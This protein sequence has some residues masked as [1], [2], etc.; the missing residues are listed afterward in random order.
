MRVLYLSAD[1]GVPVLGHKGASVHVR[2]L[3]EA[4]AAAGAEVA[5]ASPRIAFEGEQLEAAA[6]L[7]QIEPVLP[8][9]YA[10]EALLRG[11]VDRQAEQIADLASGLAVDAVYERFSLFSDGGVRAAGLLGVPHLLEVN[12]PLREEAL[13]FRTLPHSRLAEAIERAV[14]D[15]TDRVFVVS[16]TLAELLVAAG[17]AP[18]KIECVRNGVD[19]QAFGALNPVRGGEFTVGF[20]GSLK[21][22]HGV[23]VLLEGFGLALAHEPRLRLEVVG[24]GPLATRVVAS[25]L[26]AERLVYRG[27]LTH[28]EAIRA[29]AGWDVGAAPF[30]R[31]EDFYFSPLKVG[32]YMAAGSCPVASDLPVLRGLLA[33]GERGI[34]V[35]PGSAEAFA[36]ALVELA[37][38]RTRASVLGMRARTYALANL[39]WS[40]NAS[41]V[42]E[43]LATPVGAAP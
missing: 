41:R 17:V 8:K 34:L 9:T 14:L 32:E 26:P 30:P 40:E 39:S 35:E 15:L 11:A 36:A 27:Q 20:A 10:N 6:A 33:R 21:P 29:M 3:V 28:R 7:V 1:P 2:A 19:T 5:V 37:R 31:L 43:T 18:T 24:A 13:R 22:W 4:L 38:N 42:L 16:D 12:A 25:R 23:E